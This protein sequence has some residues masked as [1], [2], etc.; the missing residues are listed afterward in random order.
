MQAALPI[1][2]TADG[3]FSSSLDPLLNK[4]EMWI[5]YQALKA[6]WFANETCS[7]YFDFKL[8]RSLDEKAQLTSDNQWVV[9]PGYAYHY[10]NNNLNISPNNSIN[11]NNVYNTTA[12]I[13]VADLVKGG[14][15]IEQAIK[16]RLTAVTNIIAAQHGL[17]PLVYV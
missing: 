12:Y 17:A 8:I 4:L 13:A 2:I 11:N 1:T 6:Q 7:L 5:N 10:D 15:G 14:V 9:T 16:S 3:Q